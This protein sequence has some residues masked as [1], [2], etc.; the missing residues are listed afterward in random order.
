MGWC[1]RGRAERDWVVERVR[2]HTE[3]ATTAV[4]SLGIPHAVVDYGEYLTSPELV[5]RRLSEAC[6]IQIGTQDLNVRPDLNHSSHLGKVS[7]HFRRTLKK[8]PR[9]PVRKLEEIVPRRALQSLFPERK[10]VDSKPDDL[11]DG[12]RLD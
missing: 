9:G 1:K 6:E 3:A 2:Q 12:P 8:L 4:Y 7:T 5:V 11:G 10:Y